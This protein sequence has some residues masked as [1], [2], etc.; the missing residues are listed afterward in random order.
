MAGTDRLIVAGA[1]HDAITA[2]ELALKVSEGA[3]QPATALELETVLHGH[4]AAVTRWT[5]L[6]VDPD[7]QRSRTILA[8]A[9]R[10]LAA[11]KALAVPDRRDRRRRD[12][13][14][15]RSRRDTGGAHRACRAP[16]RVPAVA[17]SLL[18]SAVALQLLTERLAG[19][20]KRR[21]CRTRSVART[22]PRPPPTPDAT[23]GAARRGARRSA[24]CGAS[25]AVRPTCP[26]P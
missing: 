24:G 11:A 2:R 22:P 19:A 23:S 6:V 21:G 17:G 14:R 13:R 4:L 20:Q 5:G 18:A 16:G 15:D 10:L 3:R 26:R 12:R 7:R 1:G 25:R 9:H 8:R